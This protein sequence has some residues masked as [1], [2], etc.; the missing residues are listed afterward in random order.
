MEILMLF[1][2]AVLAY[3]LGSIPTAVWVGQIFY[4]LGVADYGISD[5]IWPEHLGS[6]RAVVSVS[7]SDANVEVTIP[8]RMKFYPTNANVIVIE[9]ESG[10]EL[11]QV[12]KKQ[13][14][15][16]SGT[17]CFRSRGEGIYYVYYCL[18]QYI[19]IIKR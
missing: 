16:F 14:D 13:C 18:H 7:V 3:L 19:M 2:A 15:R 10:A 11:K 12:T 4:G 8:W 1:G 5:Q 9:A 17:I 6:Q